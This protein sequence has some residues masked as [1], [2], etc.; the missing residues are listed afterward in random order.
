MLHTFNES[1]MKSS[2]TNCTCS[3]LSFC[4]IYYSTVVCREISSLL[5]IMGMVKHTV[6]FVISAKLNFCQCKLIN[7]RPVSVCACLC[8]C[9]FE[10]NISTIRNK[11]MWIQGAHILFGAAIRH[12]KSLLSDSSWQVLTTALPLSRWDGMA[13]GRIWALFRTACSSSFKQFALFMWKIHLSTNLIWMH[14]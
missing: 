1:G 7:H 3:T 8:V 11:S 6:V 4:L 14:G 13:C 2:R 12:A 10:C 5:L 9:V